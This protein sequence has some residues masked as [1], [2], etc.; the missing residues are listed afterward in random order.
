VVKVRLPHLHIRSR[1]TA[2][3]NDYYHSWL[4]EEITV[5]C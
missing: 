5:C 1:S 2:T 3:Y 4:R